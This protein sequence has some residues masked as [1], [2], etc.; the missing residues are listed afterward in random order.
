MRMR[1]KLATTIAV[2]LLTIAAIARFCSWMNRA[3]DAWFW[4]GAAGALCLLVFAPGVL[5]AIWQAELHELTAMM[6]RGRRL[7]K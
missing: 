3:S 2:L 5:A 1:F 7:T 6:R 4:S